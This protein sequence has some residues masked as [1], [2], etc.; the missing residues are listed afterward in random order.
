MNAMDKDSPNYF[1]LPVF[2]EPQRELEPMGYEN[3]V[4]EFDEI[5]KAFR[6]F[7]R[8]RE[9]GVIPEFRM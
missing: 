7:E 2:T 3:A 1:E 8:P 9:P 6:L 5:I 4:R